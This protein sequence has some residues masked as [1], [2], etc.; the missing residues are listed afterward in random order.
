MRATCV[1]LPQGPSLRSGLCCPGPSTLNRPHPPHSQAHHNF[2]A[3]RFIC[4]AFAVRERLGDPR[5]VPGFHCPFLPGMPSSPTP[6]S[7]TSIFFQSFD[8]D[9]AF[10]TLLPARHS[11][12]SRNPFHAGLPFRGFTG[13]LPLRPARLLAPLY[14]SDWTVQPSGA[15]TSRL[16]TGRSPSLLLDIST[17]V[18][19]LLCWRD[20][21]P[22]EWQLASLHNKQEDKTA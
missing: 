9:M 4:D 7:S 6:G 20:S 22:L 19:G 15:F 17:T 18:T 14:G 5:V 10:A 1:A 8:A 12:H 13:S 11:R 3:R 21:H 16:P 2:I